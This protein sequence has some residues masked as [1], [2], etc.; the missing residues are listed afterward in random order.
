VDYVNTF[1]LQI[2]DLEVLLSVSRMSY[3]ALQ[4][5][6]KIKLYCTDKE[7]TKLHLEELSLMI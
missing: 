2:T 3:H 6:H 7:V 5:N 4:R 1:T